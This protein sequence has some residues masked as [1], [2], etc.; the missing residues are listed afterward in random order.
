MSLANSAGIHLGSTPIT[1]SPGPG[2][3]LYG[4]NPVVGARPKMR[5]S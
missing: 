1:I 5:P 2:I 4:G 3:A